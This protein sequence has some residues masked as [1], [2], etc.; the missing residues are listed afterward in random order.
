[1]IDTPLSAAIQHVLFIPEIK[2][3]SFHSVE[4]TNPSK[5]VELSFAQ[6]NS[7]SSFPH[8][9]TYPDGEGSTEKKSLKIANDN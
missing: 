9:S 1:M 2:K 7:L 3:N 8:I 5:E 6:P 4:K